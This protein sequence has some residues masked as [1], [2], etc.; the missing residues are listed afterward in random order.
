MHAGA[1]LGEGKPLSPI[2]STLREADEL[3]LVL[4]NAAND[5]HSH[6][7]AQ[8]HLAAIVTS[9]PSAVV[10]LSHTG[11]VRA[12]NA[13]AARLFGYQEAEVMGR[14]MAILEPERWCTRTARCD[15]RMD[16]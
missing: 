2:H 6:M 13:A 3:S 4:S 14:P 10:S 5:L 16:A 8:A 11:N 9:S 1:A 7:G 12:W 15:T